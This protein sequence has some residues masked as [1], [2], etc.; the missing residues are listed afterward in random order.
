MNKIMLIIALATAA[1]TG[2]QTRITAEK[3][4]EQALPIQEVVT[5]NGQDQVITRGYQIASGGWYATARSPLYATEALDGLELGVHTNGSVTLA[6]N[7]YQRDLSTNAVVMV[8]NLMTGGTKL[9]TA[10]GETYAK[11]AGGASAD[12]IMAVA[13]KAYSLFA[14]AGGNADK[15]S[16]SVDEAAKSLTVSDGSICVTCDANGNCTPSLCTDCVVNQ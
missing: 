16:V 6:L 2:C 13:K 8:D 5:V 10:I 12:A 14:T 15:A 9:I 7:R 3:N 11:I 4:P 1:L